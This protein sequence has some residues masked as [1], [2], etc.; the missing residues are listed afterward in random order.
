MN[1]PATILRWMGWK[2][3]VSVPDYPKCIICVAP[4]TSNMDFIIGKL[5]Y[6]S[7]G[8]DAGFLMKSSWFFPPL[9][10]FFKSIGGVPVERKKKRHSLVEILV[11]RFRESSKLAIAV[12]PEGTRSRNPK[13]RT[14]FL[15]IARQADV[16]IVL[17]KLDYGTKTASM[18]D[19][20][21]PTGN[22]END[23]KAIKDCYRGVTARYPENFAI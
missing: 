21:Y 18:T 8:R 1:I 20:F 22:V 19:V 11:E 17:A 5:A 9:G 15:E 14:G 7:I 4:H 6:S 3:V 10:W 13:W 2:V 16:P 23:M 12:T